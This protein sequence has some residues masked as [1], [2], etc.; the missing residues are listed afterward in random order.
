LQSAGGKIGAELQ[1]CEVEAA[2]RKVVAEIEVE[3]AGGQ[4]PPLEPFEVQPMTT[5]NR[6]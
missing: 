2:R 1:V 3:R 6:I 4:G 5:M